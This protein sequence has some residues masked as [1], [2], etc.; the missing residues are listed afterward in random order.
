MQIA[1]NHSL[2]CEKSILFARYRY[3]QRNFLIF[4]KYFFLWV[5][6]CVSVWMCVCVWHSFCFFS[7]LSIS[8]PFQDTFIDFPRYCTASLLKRIRPLFIITCQTESNLRLRKF[9]SINYS[10]RDFQFRHSN[11]LN[12]NM[13]HKPVDSP[14]LI[15]E[16]KISISHLMLELIQ[17][18]KARFKWDIYRPL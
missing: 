8:G 7:A 13:A 15:L 11:V 5:Y 1:F 18:L 10:I 9:P 2:Q 6:V 17:V 4:P 3:W 12:L 14:F 16:F